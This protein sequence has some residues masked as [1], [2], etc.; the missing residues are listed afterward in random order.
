MDVQEFWEKLQSEGEEKVRLN[1]AQGIYG[2]H[3]KALAE[4]W[5]RRKEMERT[6]SDLKKR[7]AQLEEQLQLQKSQ[8]KAK[9]V[10][11]WA[12][13]ISVVVSIFALIFS[14]K[15]YQLSQREDLTVS[16][17]RVQADYETELIK[18]GLPGYP[19]VLLTYWECV[20]TNNNDK[21]L[22]ILDYAVEQKAE[23]YPAR[24]PHMI[25]GLFI[26]REKSLKLPLVIEPGKSAKF[27]LR[28]GLTIDPKAY[29]IIDQSFLLLPQK[30][31]F[32]IETLM[33]HLA[34]KG[35]DF[36]GN[37]IEPIWDQ[38]QMIGLRIPFENRKEQFFI[39]TFKTGR[40]NYFRDAAFWYKARTF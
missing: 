32:L 5:L 37:S 7:D 23:D 8:T 27:L 1:L 39:I 2:P 11:A 40:G 29:E 17:H 28:L 25:R 15:A 35:I 21:S 18:I 3:K 36:Y 12:A 16:I 31:K 13:T 22:S 10:T 26:S 30:T 24:Y 33:E 34:E 19:A 38:H 6:L 20:L 9:W 4:E 14:K